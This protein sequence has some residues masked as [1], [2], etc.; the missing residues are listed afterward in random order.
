MRTTLNVGDSSRVM[1][2]KVEDNAEDRVGTLLLLTMMT[3]A[4]ADDDEG[5]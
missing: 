3:E 4:N 5:Q 2:M 1:M